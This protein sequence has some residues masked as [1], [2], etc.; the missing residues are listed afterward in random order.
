MSDGLPPLPAGAEPIAVPPLPT[1]AVPLPA[2]AVEEAPIP[3]SPLPS[4]FPQKQPKSSV[5]KEAGLGAAAGF[6]TPEIMKGLGAPLARIPGPVG[7]AGTAIQA[8]GEAAK[9]FGPRLGQAVFGGVGGATGEVAAQKF[10][11]SPTVAR[12]VGGFG[13]AFG[14]EALARGLASKSGPVLSS[15]I[16]K[17][18]PGAGTAGRTLG[19]MSAEDTPTA[20]ALTLNQQQREFIA[21]KLQA[22]RGGER[23]PA[24]IEK[25]QREIYGYLRQVADDALTQANEQARQTWGQATSLLTAAEAASGQA[26]ANLA[27]QI[28]RI[29]G[30]FEQSAIKLEN[31][32]KETARLIREQADTATKQILDRAE[33]QGPEMIAGAKAEADAIRQQAD[34]EVR[35]L[36]Q[37]T[38][39]KVARMNQVRDRLRATSGQ[40]VSAAEQE[41]RG[42]GERLTPTELGERLRQGFMSTLDKLKGVREANVQKYKSEAF[43]A[44]LAKE[45]AGER[46]QSTKAYADAIGQI[47]S[48]LKSAETGLANVPTGESR[49]TLTK[50]RDLLQR[51]IRQQSVDP[52]TGEPVIKYQPLSFQALENMRRMLRDRAYGLPA[53]GYDA[54][55]QQQAGRLA[56]AVESIQKEFSPGFEK[57]L[58]QY[59]ADSQPLNQFKNKLGK[60]MVGTQV[61]DMGQFVTDPAALAGQAFKTAS[62]VKQLTETV[63][64]AEAENLAR[65]YFAD[66]LRGGKAADVDKALDAAR[67]WIGLFPKLRE[68]MT[69]LSSRAGVAER[70][71][72]KREA[73]AKGL[74]TQV[75]KT[76]AE[77]AK[78][79]AERPV[80]A[81]EKAAG[82]ETKAAK[83]AAEVLPAAEEEAAKATRKSA[84]EAAA[85]EAEIR[86]Q[87]EASAKAVERRKAGLTEE[88]ERGIAEATKTAERAAAEKTAAGKAAEEAG[89]A[90]AVCWWARMSWPQ[91]GCR[92]S[93]SLTRPPS[94]RLWV[95]P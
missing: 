18:F 55:G 65:S 68:E 75:G 4:P 87:I 70:T 86:K 31:T 91:T 56:D 41:V 62:T 43:D 35:R 45:K 7:R 82:I 73:L 90:R 24:V 42:I 89:K 32:G 95:M 26:R 84:E 69:S 48:E 27:Q 80:A 58:S 17:I 14:T 46:Y 1:G 30:Q 64:T 59:A 9:G 36:T 15:L 63:G 40:R 13:G 52:A 85:R 44:A 23:D 54:I 93:S 74:R 11:E 21:K 53:E 19:M 37:E 33:K 49:D 6:A 94:G 16:N 51:G 29:Q 60:A 61:F 25:T 28:G 5:L 79:A 71:A 22:I 8:M 76:T 10:P 38:N 78:E 12:L 72:T 83:E 47:N 3:G 67:D 2:G 20:G 92:R 81:A 77:L 88:T 50:V 57:Y 39:A 66:V 34:E